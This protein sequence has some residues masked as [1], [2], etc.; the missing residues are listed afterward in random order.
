MGDG[1][2]KVAFVRINLFLITTG[3]SQ[4]DFALQFASGRVGRISFDL[5]IS[6][7]IELRVESEFA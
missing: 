5:K 4:Q 1:G 3:P 6:Q 7:I 2:Q